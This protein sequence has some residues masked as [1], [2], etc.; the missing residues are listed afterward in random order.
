M[1]APVIELVSFPGCPNRDAARAML[2]ERL[3]AKGL[4]IPVREV[5]STHPDNRER[6]GGYASPTVLVNGREICPGEKAGA[7]ACRI[8]PGGRG[9]PPQD[10]VDAALDGLARADSG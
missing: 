5:D 3:A 6:Y 4:D 10:A 9:L 7:D 8:Y 2:E 1:P